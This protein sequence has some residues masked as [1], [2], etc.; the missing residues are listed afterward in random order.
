MYDYNLCKVDYHGLRGNNW[1]YIHIGNVNALSN[2]QETKFYNRKRKLRMCRHNNISF[3]SMQR[4]RCSKGGGGTETRTRPQT[5]FG[6]GWHAKL[7]GGFP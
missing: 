5:E 7:A 3:F 6:W 4:F 2:S 1:W